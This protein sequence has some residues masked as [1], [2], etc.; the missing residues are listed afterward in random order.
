MNMC[1][2]CMASFLQNPIYGFV[3]AFA[4]LLALLLII[5]FIAMKQR[6]TTT[7]KLL[8]LYSILFFLFFPAVF[9]FYTQTCGGSLLY[10]C[11]PVQSFFYT[12]LIAI[13]IS[14]SIGFVATPFL[15]R[16]SSKYQR[17]TEKREEWK[18]KWKKGALLKRIQDYATQMGIAMPSVFIIDKAEPLAFSLSHIRPSLF[19]TVGL[20]D[21]LQ[22]K[23]VDAVLL[24][25]LGHIKHRAS[26]L[27]FTNSLLRFFFP[28]AN[29]NVFHNE[30]DEEEQHADQIAVTMQGTVRY[31][32]AAKQ[33]MNAYYTLQHK[34]KEKHFKGEY[35]P[36]ENK[37]KGV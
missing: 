18:E 20:F 13:G 21:L 28:I 12:T 31:L 25:E 35:L 37:Q 1:G 23:E 29:F 14:A 16:F 17:I 5:L 7:K 3:T 24:H 33:K 26:F 4:F 30:L 15:Y 6:L 11:N 32:T 34:L 2:G 27:K 9:Y 8:L 36:M 19:V 22:K 10:S